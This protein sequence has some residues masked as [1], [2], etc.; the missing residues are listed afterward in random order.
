MIG[1][2]V[3]HI[4]TSSNVFILPE[5]LVFTSLTFLQPKEFTL[6][7]YGEKVFGDKL[8]QLLFHFYF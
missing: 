1:L 8:F 4:F 2:K 5:A 6:T 7:L 3:T